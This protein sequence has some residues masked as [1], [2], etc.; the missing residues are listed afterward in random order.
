LIAASWCGGGQSCRQVAAI[1][2]LAQLGANLVT[3]APD[4]W[5]SQRHWHT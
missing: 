1:G 5:S 4:A 3:L 2:G